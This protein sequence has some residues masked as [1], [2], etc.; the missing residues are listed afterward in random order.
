MVLWWLAWWYDGCGDGGGSIVGVVV[1]GG[2]VSEFD[3][4]VGGFICLGGG[5]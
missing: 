5:Q 3:G 1:F 4:R 2:W